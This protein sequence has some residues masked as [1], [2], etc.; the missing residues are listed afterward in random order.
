MSKQREVLSIREESLQWNDNYSIYW[1]HT[2]NQIYHILACIIWGFNNRVGGGR[3]NT[4]WKASTKGRYSS[5]SPGSQKS[6]IRVLRDLVSSMLFLACRWL[7]YC[8]CSTWLSPVFLHLCCLFPY[9]ASRSYGIRAS[10][11]IPIVLGLAFWFSLI[12]II[13]LSV[14]FPNTATVGA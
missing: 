5:H 4:S 7:P 13:S 11:M 8:H 1:K 6:N 14:L 10:L 2:S 3:S 9:R 12:L